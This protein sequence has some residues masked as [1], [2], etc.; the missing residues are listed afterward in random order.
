MWP[1]RARRYAYSCQR[2]RDDAALTAL[3]PVAHVVGQIT[4]GLRDRQLV[5]GVVGLGIDVERLPH[6]LGAGE[7]APEREA[8]PQRIAFRVGLPHQNAPQI[9]VPA[10]ADAEHVKDLS[11]EPVGAAPQAPHRVHG[12]LLRRRQLDFDAQVDFAL[13]RAEE[14]HDLERALT[15]AELDG[16]DVD[17]VVEFLAWRRFQP[18][19]RVEQ[20]LAGDEHHG[21]AIARDF[22]AKRPWDRGDRRSRSHDERN[23]WTELPNGSEISS[24]VSGGSRS[25]L[26]SSGCSSRRFTAS[27]SDSPLIFL[28]SSRMPYSS[29][30]GRGGQPGT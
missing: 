14:V 18:P 1:A 17:Q 23:W 4:G 19:H 30:S 11:L 26:S 9:G 7:A 5:Q 25:P 20:A 10:E 28:W 15:I 8:F 6:L 24:I 22:A 27:N 21:L 12:E 16:C 3:Q 13:E 2:V 29:P